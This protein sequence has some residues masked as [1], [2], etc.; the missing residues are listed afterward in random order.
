[1]L[2]LLDRK[3]NRIFF[4]FLTAQ[5]FWT[6]TSNAQTPRKFYSVQVSANV[7]VSP[8]LINL[9]WPPDPNATSYTIS[10]KT[11]QATSWNSVATLPGTATGYADTSV[12][13][14]S[15][16]EY[17]IFKTTSGNY[18]GYGYLFAGIN[19]PMIDSR[20]KLILVVENT[21][22]ADLAFE[23][24]RLQ[25]DLI[26]DGWSVIRYDVNRSDPV[27]NVKALIKSAYDADPANATAV[28]L[29][30]R[31]PVPYSGDI[32][33]DGHTNHQGAWPADV[34]YGEMSGNW[35]DNTVTST[36]AELTR[37]WNLPGDGKFDQ[38]TPPGEVNLQIGR[39]DLANMT[40]FSNVGLSE[41]DLLRR[42]LNKDH[43]FRH[44]LLPVQRRGFLT[45]DFSNTDFDPAAGSGWR[46]LSAFFGANQVTEGAYGTYFPTL[47][48]QSYLWS[49]GA[50]GGQY[51]YCN[52]V[53]TSDDFATQ[54]PQV[55][56]TM[57]MGSK[58][59]D[60]DTESNILRAP[61]GTRTYTLTCSYSG[62]PQTVYHHM[63]LGENIGYSIRLTQNNETN[64]LYVAG[65]GSHQVHI[66]LMGDPSLRMHPV[67]PPANLSATSSAKISLNWQ[68]STDTAIQ[69]YHV[70]RAASSAG[71]FARL[72]GSPLTTTAYQDS[73]L[74]GIYTYMVRAV[75]L[76][77]SGGGTYY[78]PSQGVF[79]TA[80]TTNAP[81]PP[82]T[83]APPTPPA[84]NSPATNAPQG[85]VTA[86]NLNYTFKTALTNDGSTSVAR[87]VVYGSFIKKGQVIS[88][89]L[90]LV[91][92]GLEPNFTYQLVSLDAAE[93][94][95]PVTEVTT[96][97]KGRFHLVYLKK[98][99]GNLH[100]GGQL[101][102]EALNPLC[103]ISDLA[104]L[105]GATQIVLR[106]H[107]STP[108]KM[109][110]NVKCNLENS[111]F[112]PEATGIVRLRANHKTSHSSFRATR[113]S[114]NTSYL[115]LLNESVT[116][117]AT[118]DPRG[119]INLKTLP[120]GNFSVLEINSISLI[121]ATGSN[122]VLTAYGLG[123]PCP[124][125]EPAASQ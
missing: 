106:A 5:F 107:I 70:Y 81:A 76:E 66:A 95:I 31:V 63:G 56:F 8:P 20:G 30:G 112:V 115:L 11:K 113:L 125:G 75:K 13:V 37:N 92:L 28:F 47:T 90:K 57:L 54:D 17:K 45:D 109:A 7:Q 103:D 104:I 86:A 33:P 19:A 68:A 67:I 55:V 85:Q 2:N 100:P 50:G 59:G 87:G 52:G 78:N 124:P 96:D 116:Q 101:L 102:P 23:L 98:G 84:T 114:P 27:T 1:M 29:F 53:G 99:E 118:S 79:L 38:S 71:P 73:P 42:Y 49:Y 74:S 32:F 15:A 60:W 12:T 61:L 110:Y 65:Q 77:R 93:N 35:T 83:N 44:A 72:T 64:G 14:G 6:F 41:K 121:D 46:N 39:V 88:Q 16:F 9:V 10:R 117:P 94:A 105:N 43:N 119:K 26:G 40:A 97:P 24:Q 122:V 18:S 120:L 89:R 34:Y 25:Q 3:F 36:G 4:Y 80:S 58:F 69:G 22:A 91:A 82:T 111:G 108:D 123:I 21:Y 48:G 62:A 51:T